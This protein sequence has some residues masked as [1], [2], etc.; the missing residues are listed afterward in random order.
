MYGVGSQ[1]NRTL[2]NRWQ[3]NVL[4]TYCWHH[5][6]RHNPLGIRGDII[7]RKFSLRLK[8]TYGGNALDYTLCYRLFTRFKSGHRSIE[9]DLRQGRLSTSTDNAHAQKIRDMV[10]ANRQRARR[11]EDLHRVVPWHFDR[12]TE[13]SSSCSKVCPLVLCRKSNNCSPLSSPF[14]LF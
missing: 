4:M 3:R 1:N 8:Q 12:K 7:L 5:C 9:D 13:Q 14:F 6:G 10:N 11:R 2:W